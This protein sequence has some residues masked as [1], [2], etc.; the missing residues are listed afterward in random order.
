M[1]KKAK[2]T[3]IPMENM[4]SAMLKIEPTAEKNSRVRVILSSEGC[5]FAM[6]LS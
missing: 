1:E 3:N 6:V 2:N 5:D 4:V